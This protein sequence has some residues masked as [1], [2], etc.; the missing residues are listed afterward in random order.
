MWI[1]KKATLINHDRIASIRRFLHRC[2]DVSDERT[3]RNVQI[4]LVIRVKFLT[5]DH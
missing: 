3:D 5:N 1:N 2:G 4:Q